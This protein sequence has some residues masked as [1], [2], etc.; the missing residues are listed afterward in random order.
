MFNWIK[1]LIN[2]RKEKLVNEL[3][4]NLKEISVNFSSSGPIIKNLVST[5]IIVED[6]GLVLEPGEVI[7]L[8]ERNT[9]M[10]IDRSVDLSH[11]LEQGVLMDLNDR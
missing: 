1:R 8:K 9:Q 6:L 7:K 2:K 10:E 5:K 11:L 3:I 4:S